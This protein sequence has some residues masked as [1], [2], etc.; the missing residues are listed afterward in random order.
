MNAHKQIAIQALQNMRGDNTARARA[1]FRGM[2]KPQ[3]QEQY[4]QS[5]KTRAQILSDY[6]TLDAR[7]D[8]AIAWIKS[9]PE[10]KLQP[11]TTS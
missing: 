9:I 7:I 10:N 4:G 11:D 1:A 2:S 5:G 3:M 8:A 6:E